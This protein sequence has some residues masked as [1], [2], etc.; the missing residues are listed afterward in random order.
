MKLDEIVENLK[1]HELEFDLAIKNAGRTRNLIFK[2]RRK[3]KTVE[4]VKALIIEVGQKTQKDVNGYIENSVTLALQSVFGKEF[5]FRIRQEIKRDQPEVHFDFGE[6][7]LFFDP[8]EDE[9]AGGRIDIAA[10]ALK[11]IDWSLSFPQSVSVLFLDEP[12][13]NV[14]KE[15]K[16]KALQLLKEVCKSKNMQIIMVTHIPEFVAGA[17]NI[18]EL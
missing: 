10:F 18:I 1:K 2:E 8:K 12:F 5:S 14:S 17:D 4:K 13:K 6:N 7:D 9:V 11:V 16:T 15:Y 3:L